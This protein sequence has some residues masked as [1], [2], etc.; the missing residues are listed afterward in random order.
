MNVE[1]RL[2]AAARAYGDAVRPDEEGSMDVIRSRGASALRRRRAVV[3]GLSGVVVVVAG[4]LLA[5]QLA[6]DDGRVDTVPPAGETTTTGDT[7][8]TVGEITT[9]TLPVDPIY[10]TSIW[11]PADHEQYEDPVDAALSFLD[12]YVGFVD[13]PVSEARLAE[14]RVVEV[15]VFLRGEDGSVR[16]DLV[17]ATIHLRQ[18][19][20]DTWHV[21]LATSE[22]VELDTPQSL[23][24]VES[25]VAISGRGRG[26]E[27]TLVASV[28]DGTGAN[29][30]QEVVMGGCCEELEPFDARVPLPGTPPTSTGSVV[31]M[32]TTGLDN[33]IVG[34]T[35]VPIRFA[36]AVT[37]FQVY[38]HQGEEVVAV[39]RSVPKTT[40]VLRAALT[41]LLKGPAAD[42]TGFTSPFSAD[43]AGMLVDVTITDGLAVVDFD[44]DLPDR[45]DNWSTSAMSQAVLDE[46]AATIFQF[47]TVQR[48]ELRLE[49]DC[50]AFFE[51]MER[52]C[53]P[54]TR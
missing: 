51:S 19:A 29:L 11:P 3:A 44:S 49:G 10:E 26:F 36:D 8:T 42:D 25:P 12:E 52:T 39:E 34:F 15:D 17:K 21:T 13:P 27:A 18:A 2:R 32:A 1:D 4:A 6:D 16:E 14:P 23:D 47:P 33:G 40:A 45:V 24:V 38:F 50:D 5:V 43:T 54:L 48:I 35:A 20:D 9:T 31:V 30:V 22:D 28:R 53:E 7:T 41:E 37:T 46:L